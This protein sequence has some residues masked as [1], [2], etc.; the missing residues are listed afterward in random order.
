MRILLSASKEGMKLSGGTTPGVCVAVRML[1][2]FEGTRTGEGDTR[3]L[4][5]G[6]VCA[7]RILIGC[8]FSDGWRLWDDGG[9]MLGG[10]SEVGDE[11]ARCLEGG[12]VY[13]LRIL[14]G[15]IFSGG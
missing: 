2:G 9:R 5:D 10:R 14:T 13:S 1:A 8:T 12:L 11:V 4:E 6:R 3:C 15:R 7:L